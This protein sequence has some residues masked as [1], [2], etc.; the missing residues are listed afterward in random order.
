MLLLFSYVLRT[1]EYFLSGTPRHMSVRLRSKI[2][3]ANSPQG[4]SWDIFQVVLSLVACYMHILS[5]YKENAIDD[6]TVTD[7][8][9]SQFEITLEVTPPPAHVLG[10]KC[11]KSPRRRRRPPR[12]SNDSA[13]RSTPP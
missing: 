1:V 3:L 8:P 12:A 9:Q 10:L 4:R 2:K 13:A 7:V 5:T 11:T 6:D